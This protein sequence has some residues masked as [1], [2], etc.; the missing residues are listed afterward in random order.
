MMLEIDGWKVGIKFSA[1]HFIPGHHKCSRL[2]GHDYGVKIRIYGEPKDCVLY[3]FVEL[4]K[5]VRKIADELD[6]HLLLPSSQ[7]F[8]KH[9]IRGEE[10]L[11]EFQGKRYIFPRGDVMFLNLRIT[12]AEELSRY[13]AERII[14]KINFPENVKGIEV[15]VEEGPGQGA[16]YYAPVGDER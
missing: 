4:K 10:V 1:S 5:E 15:C 13:F 2:H 9:E 16:W 12:T 3:D 14:E 11:V 6:H 8:I 7:E